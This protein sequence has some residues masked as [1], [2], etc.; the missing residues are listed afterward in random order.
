MLKQEV[1][2]SFLAFVAIFAFASCEGDYNELSSNDYQPAQIEAEM[3]LVFEDVDNL[4]YLG[5]G[6]AGLLEENWNPEGE[7][8]VE[9]AII[10]FHQESNAITLDFGGGCFSAG[11]PLRKGKVYIHYTGAYFAPKT[12]I[13]TTLEDY[14]V[15][16][17]E[18]EG[19]RVIT[20]ISE[21]MEAAPKF[22]VTLRNGQLTWADSTFAT[23]S[24]NYIRS[25][26]RANPSSITLLLEGA[27]RGTN[28]KGKIYTTTTTS[29][30]V[31]KRFCQRESL[32]FPVQGALLIETMNK[33][34]IVMDFGGGT[35]DHI[36]E[37]TINERSKEIQLPR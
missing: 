12:V 2:C 22:Q 19:T 37:V 17:I 5:L 14:S 8:P 28:N 7:N 35:C 3:G 26:N 15:F 23:R 24:A 21:N 10:T 36:A 33:P 6:Y 18:V 1:H 27:A 20:N 30:I 34:T 11:Q 4:T 29:P 25:W 32:Y 31:Y 16:N 13:T 9:C